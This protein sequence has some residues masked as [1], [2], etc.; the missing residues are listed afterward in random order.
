MS[1]RKKKLI[2]WMNIYLNKSITVIPKKKKRN[3]GK[4][5]FICVINNSSRLQVFKEIAL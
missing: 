3:K 5:V 1:S 2:I 4:S